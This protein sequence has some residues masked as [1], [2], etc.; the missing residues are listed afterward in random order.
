MKTPHHEENY[1]KNL[2]EIAYLYMV[3]YLVNLYT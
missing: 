1:C 3:P 2:G